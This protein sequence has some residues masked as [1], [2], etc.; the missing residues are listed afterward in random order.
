MATTVY[1]LLQYKG[2]DGKVH[3]PDGEGF[4]LPDETPEEQAELAKLIEYKIVTKSA[5]R[6]RRIAEKASEDDDSQ[7]APRRKS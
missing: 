2:Q 4:D 5:S 7:R 3:E 6:G 1:A